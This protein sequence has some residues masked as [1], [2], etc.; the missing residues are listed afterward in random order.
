MNKILLFA[1]NDA[2]FGI[3]LTYVKEIIET[4]NI[5]PVPLA[6]SFVSGLL[7]HRGSFLTII[8]LALLL[9]LSPGKVDQDSRIIILDDK[10]MDIGI[11][12][13][14]VMGT[15]TLDSPGGEEE[16]RTIANGDNPEFSKMALKGAEGIP[17][18]TILDSER[19]LRSVLE[20]NF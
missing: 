13:K 3:E 18:I 11:L 7:N 17:D 20:Y 4:G 5:R 15:K 2:T 8:H 1:L 6:P 14:K 16:P 9:G 12:V 10:E 19:L